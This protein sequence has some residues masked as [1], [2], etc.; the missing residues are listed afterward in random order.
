[1]RDNLVFFKLRVLNIYK[2]LRNKKLCCQ[3]FLHL[4]YPIQLKILWGLVEWVGDMTWH[5][6]VSMEDVWRD[7]CCRIKEFTVVVNLTKDL[8]FVRLSTLSH[9]GFAFTTW[10]PCANPFFTRHLAS[11]FHTLSSPSQNSQEHKQVP[12]T[13]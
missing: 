8:T 10:F 9:G 2:K 12:I 7:R 6:M 1:M 4:L 13:Y 3:V 11:L 5:E